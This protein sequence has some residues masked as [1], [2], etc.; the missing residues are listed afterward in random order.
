MIEYQVTDTGIS[1]AEIT[2]HCNGLAIGGWEV[3]AV[4]PLTDYPGLPQTVRVLSR[5][6]EVLAH[7][8]AVILEPEPELPEAAQLDWDGMYPGD[9]FSMNGVSK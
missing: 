4:I 1:K 5:R 2:D 7:D 9:R 3:V 8:R 6:E